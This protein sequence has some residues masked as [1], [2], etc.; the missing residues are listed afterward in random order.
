[1][2]RH[3]RRPV[4][5]V[6]CWAALALVLAVAGARASGQPAPAAPADTLARAGELV[7]SRQFGQAATLL[8]G[9]VSVHPEDRGAREMLAYAL[10]CVG[11]LGGEREVRSALAAE[12]P[13]D[14]GIQRDY[15]R[16]LE[17]SG[18][19]EGALSAYVRARD[20]GGGQA[21]GLDAAIERVRG[22]TAWEIGAPVTM[23]SDPEAVSTRVQA[24]AAA[25]LGSDAQLSLLGAHSTARA[26]GD[27]GVGMAS[28]ELTLSLAL[29]NNAG[30]SLVA[31]PRLQRIAPPG[32]AASDLGLGGAIAGRARL[33]AGLEAQASAEAGA[34]W[35]ESPITVLHG[36]R[37][38]GAEGH[39]YSHW[40]AGR[41]LLQAGART[42]RL[43]IL[44]A[45]PA[46]RRP[47]ASQTLGVAG[48]DVVLWR[49]PGEAVRG[50]MLD[51][52]L[53]G[54]TTVSSALTAAYRHYD[55]SAR[56][57]PG[58]A[59]LVALVP[60]DRVDEASLAGSLASPGGR[61]GV[62]LRA[63]LARDSARPARAW[64]AGGAFLWA[65]LA[66][67]RLALGYEEATEISTGLVGRRREGWV[68]LHVHL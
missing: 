28:D 21:P 50:E 3:R 30:A 62:E 61:L 40:L 49:E 42:R 67:V 12:F 25:P 15:G 34:P 41:L 38:T 66:T 18:D 35:D 54:R 37:A 57:T 5:W 55:A 59:A 22:R 32:G 2:F 63:G 56:A 13:D 24:G 6:P 29:R 17:R 48:L 10:E 45:D 11:D 51:E 47:T 26:R 58:F 16:V 19:D 8:R 27:A 14:P 1:M 33:G 52:S 4:S 64:R 60:E 44:A 65:P 39:L 20:L 9:L 46:A 53:V 7:R 31:G 36:G 23:V 43:S 68:S